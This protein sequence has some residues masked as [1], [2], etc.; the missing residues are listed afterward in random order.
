AIPRRDIEGSRREVRQDT[1][2]GA[3]SLESPARY[4]ALTKSQSET[5]SEGKYVRVRFRD[6]HR[7][8]DVNQCPKQALFIARFH[9]LRLTLERNMTGLLTE[10]EIGELTPS[11]LVEHRTPIPTQIVS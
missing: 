11:E 4:R 9:P 2:A 1:R 7:R 3:N 5:S 10:E 8:Y 6:Q